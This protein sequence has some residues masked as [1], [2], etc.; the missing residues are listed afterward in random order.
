MLGTARVRDALLSS[1]DQDAAVGM[2]L[3]AG[4]DLDPTVITDD[5]SLV[6]DGRVSP[7]LLWEKHRGVIASM[8]VLAA[9]L[10]LLL[11]RLLFTGRRRV[12]A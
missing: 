5:V 6:L 1:R 8:V 12:P 9:L 10:V 4:S 11:R 7:V 2:M 3:R